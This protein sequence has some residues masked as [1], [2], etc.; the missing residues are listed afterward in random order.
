MGYFFGFKLHLV[1]N[2]KGELL[3]FVITPGNMD[4]RDPL[5][6]KRFVAKLKG[7]LFGDKDIFQANLLNCFLWMEYNLSQASK[8]I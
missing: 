4:D 2:E 3:N 7:K 8:K 1:I 6:N 5:K